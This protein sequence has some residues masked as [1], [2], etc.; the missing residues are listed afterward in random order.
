MADDKEITS[1]NRQ[2]A[3]FDIDAISIE[4]LEKRLELVVGNVLSFFG[5]CGTFDGLC[6]GVFS[7]QCGAF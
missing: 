4:E 3:D 2:L 6:R 5:D 1:F 7:G